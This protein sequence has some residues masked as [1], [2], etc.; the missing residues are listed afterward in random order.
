MAKVVFE[1][2]DDVITDSF[3]IK[4][5]DFQKIF[6]EYGIAV[7]K[8]LLMHHKAYCGMSIFAQSDE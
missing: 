4:I 6:H 7:T 3:S 8:K 5:E 2:S 1:E